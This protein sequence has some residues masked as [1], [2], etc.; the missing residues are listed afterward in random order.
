MPSFKSLN[1]VMLIGNLGGNPEVRATGSGKSVTTFQ[2]ATN[3]SWVDKNGQRQKR[4]EWHRIVAWGKIGQ[5]CAKFLHQGSLCM[6]EG[7]IRHRTWA[8]KEGKE[9]QSD[10]VEASRLVVLEKIE[11]EKEEVVVADDDDLPF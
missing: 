1:K 7:K 8:D 6:I 2:L 10:E 11:K 3:E 4:T 5:D 9:R